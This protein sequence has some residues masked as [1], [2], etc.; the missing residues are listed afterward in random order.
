MVESSRAVTNGPCCET[1]LP[2]ERH[3]L[4]KTKIEAKIITAFLTDVQLLMKV[5]NYTLN[6]TKKKPMLSSV[7]KLLN[8]TLVSKHGV[9]CL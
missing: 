2:S 6:I 4:F 7:N 8:I 5:M 9:E 1:V 3:P